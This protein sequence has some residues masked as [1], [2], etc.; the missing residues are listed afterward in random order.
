MIEA[1][2][3]SPFSSIVP[4]DSGKLFLQAFLSWA[5]TCLFIGIISLPAADIVPSSYPIFANAREQ[6]NARKGLE[7]LDRAADQMGRES[8]INNALG[9]V[10]RLLDRDKITE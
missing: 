2:Q 9:S 5:L 7:H 6:E 1:L 4:L 8:E 10:Q 3:Y